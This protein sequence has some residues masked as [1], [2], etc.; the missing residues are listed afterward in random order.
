MAYDAAV[1]SLSGYSLNN[2]LGDLGGQA[3]D[4]SAGDLGG[5]VNIA[6]VSL[7]AA[8]MLDALQPR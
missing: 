7:L 1:L 2:L 6:E 8:A 4:I 3:T 5:S